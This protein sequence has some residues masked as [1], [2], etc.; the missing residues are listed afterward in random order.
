MTDKISDENDLKTER[1]AIYN[2]KPQIVLFTGGR[3]STLTASILMMRDIPVCLLSADN[4]CS[5]HRDI[6]EYR[7]KE[8]IK[9]FGEHLIVEYKILD[10]SGTFR[11]IALKDIETDILTYKKNLIVLGEKLALLAHAVD[12]C[13]RNDYMDINAGYTKYQEEF[14]EQRGIAIKFFEDFLRHYGINFYQPIYEDATTVEYVKYRLMQIGLSNKPLEGSTLFGDTF[15]VADNQTIHNYL[16]NK[17]EQAHEHVKFLTQDFSFGNKNR[18]RH[19]MQK[20][21]VS[22]CLLGKKVRYHGNDALCDNAILEKWKQENRLVVICPEVSAGLP[23]PR[24]SCEIVGKGGGVAVLHNKAKVM[25]HT[26]IDKTDAFLSGANKALK[27]AKTE[28][29]RIA[30]LKSKSPSCGNSVIYDGTYNDKTIAGM[31]VTAAL[32]T[33]NNIKVFNEDQI[34]EA[35]D[36]LNFLESLD[37]NQS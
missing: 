9:R 27:V 37:M 26:G 3:D 21:L 30:I 11:S 25:S 29:I 33:Q 36:F 15:S 28:N 2:K 8:L 35:L 18:F 31:G 20:I 10:I 19:R 4:G 17:K 34:S 5:I 32:L 12:F 23:V 24:P 16:L 1:D 7:I 22:A 13:L 6:T 14:P